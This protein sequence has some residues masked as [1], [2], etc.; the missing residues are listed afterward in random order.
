MTEDLKK[1]PLSGTVLSVGDK[2]LYTKTGDR[3][4][5]SEYAGHYVRT[6]DNIL[7]ESSLIVMRED[8]VI[9][10]IEEET[11]ASDTA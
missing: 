10:Y 7:E 4:H 6:A 2:C 11:D 1:P 9:V 8:E 3:V 5:F